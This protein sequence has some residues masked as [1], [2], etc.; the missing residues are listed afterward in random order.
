M[1]IFL[2]S[3]NMAITYGAHSA[4]PSIVS[5]VV[6]ICTYVCI[7]VQFHWY[8]GNLSIEIFSNQSL[9]SKHT[10]TY[11]AYTFQALKRRSS[12]FTESS[13]MPVRRTIPRSLL[14]S[15][16]PRLS[17]WRRTNTLYIKTVSKSCLCIV[18]PNRPIFC[19]QLLLKA[20]EQFGRKSESTH[21]RSV[22]TIS[23]HNI[24]YMLRIL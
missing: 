24:C 20:T 21:S 4:S 18:T 7:S 14:I 11:L 13:R 19:L 12:H 5:E 2:L 9:S 1:S 17:L 23:F 16:I 15:I 6:D 8:L 10:R 22:L 3:G